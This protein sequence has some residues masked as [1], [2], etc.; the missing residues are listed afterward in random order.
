MTSSFVA[1]RREVLPLVPLRDMVVFPHMMAPFIVGRE[2]SVRALEQ[3]LSTAH[4]RIFL[5]AQKDPKIDEPLRPDVY[6]VGVVAGRRVI[7]IED[8]PTLTHGSMS[9]GAA[10]VGA[11]AAG[12]A[13]IVDP[14]PYAVGSLAYTYAKYPN[15][16][17]ILPAMGY[18][19]AQVRDLEATI[20]ATIAA[21]G[22]D[23]VVSG[24]PIDLG[25]ILSVS[26]PLVRARYELREHTAGGL[27]AAVREALSRPLTVRSQKATAAR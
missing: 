10:V 5:V 11:R 26:K 21:T 2:S 22:A 23:A 8:G 1:T 27:E 9:Y 20:E 17:G 18:G 4:K 7:C 6:D 25:R 19:E 13:E 15:A 24:T 12:A 16:A 3:A 14:S